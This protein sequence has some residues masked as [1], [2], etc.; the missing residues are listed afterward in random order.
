[1]TTCGNITGVVSIIC[2]PEDILSAVSVML[3]LKLLEII[4]KIKGDSYANLKTG[5]LSH[6][7]MVNIINS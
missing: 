7:N 4:L 2:G 1:M 5:H 6:Y 3:M